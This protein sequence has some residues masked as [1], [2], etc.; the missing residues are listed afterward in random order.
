MRTPVLV[1]ALV[2]IVLLATL[3]IEEFVRQGVTAVGILAILII[4][5]FAVGIIGALRDQPPE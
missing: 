5:L 4:V 2:F 1:A 3:T